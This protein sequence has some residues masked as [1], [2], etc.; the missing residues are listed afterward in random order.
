MAS[1][2]NKRSMSQPPK[3]KRSFAVAAAVVLCLSLYP[4]PAQPQTGSHPLDPLSADEMRAAITLLD[5][6]NKVSARTRYPLIQLNEPPK[7]EVLA[8]N[9]GDPIRREAFVVAF[10]RDAR[11]TF[12]GVV[13]LKDK[14][15]VSWTE[16][17]GVQPA[18]LNEDVEIAVELVANDRRWQAAMHRRGIRDLDS[19]D[20][21]V[22]PAGFV[23]DAVEDKARLLRCVSFL[24]AGATKNID[25]RPIEGVVALVDVSAKRILRIVDEGDVPVPS[26][27]AEYDGAGLPTRPA[28][29]PLEVRQ[30]EGPSF[31]VDGHEVRWDKWRFRFALHP[32]EGLV[33]YQVGYEDG[34]R[35]RPILYRASLS[36]LMVNYGDASAGWYWRTVFDQGENMLGWTAMSLQPGVDAPENAVYFDSVF[37]LE[38]GEPQSMARAVA[39]YER[40]GGLLWKHAE[41]P[42]QNDSRRARQLVLSSVTSLGNYDYGFNW[43]FHQDGTLEQETLLTGIMSTKAVERV[44]DAI[45]GHAEGIHGHLVMP[46]VEAVHHQHFF[47]FRLDLD[48]DGTQNSVVEMNSE[49][50]P[51]GPSNPYGNAFVMKETLLAT[52]KAAK[53]ALNFASSR[54]WKI[55]NPRSLNSLGQSTGF[56]LL[57]GESVL[58]LVLPDSW[59][60][61]RGGLAG[62]PVWVT[63]YEP[64]ELY[65]A[66]DYPNQG[67]SGQG[68]PQMIAD[69]EKLENQDVVLWHTMGTTHIP[70][71]EDWPVMPVHRMSFKL[72]PTGFFDRNPALD[73]SR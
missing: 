29:K 34:G 4:Q 16:I 51:A 41:A 48:V 59:V 64:R 43:I 49:T 65:A 71:P 47:N 10:D 22:L 11:K 46:N 33:L 73:V 40:D 31:A 38:N 13:D 27:A 1:I 20:I 35:V 23:D 26:G 53:R 18:I 37:A 12:E 21:R 66:G 24:K 52:E 61:Q 63:H 5:A 45:P 19:V 70:R 14:R 8:F 9:P 57:T 44:S 54:R 68:L 56:T 36:E 6:D 58:P 25:A 28:L 2:P 62:F 67:K 39:I 15:V 72:A 30:K 60:L 69:D 42:D 7:A 50:V 32:R 3:Q 55:I 17:P